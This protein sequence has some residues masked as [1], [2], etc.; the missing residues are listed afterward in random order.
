MHHLD[1][2]AREAEGHGPERSLARP[3]DKVVDL[4][5]GILNLV[6][7][8]NR[9]P[10]EELLHSIEAVQLDSFGAK[11]KVGGISR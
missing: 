10:R 5:D 8:G 7:G 1:G 9:R 4:G 6:V 2:A 11:F 3:V